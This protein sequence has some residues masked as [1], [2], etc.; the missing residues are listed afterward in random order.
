MIGHSTRTGPSPSG[1][2]VGQRDVWGW[3]VALVVCA[4]GSAGAGIPAQVEGTYRLR[5]VIHV[6]PTAQPSIRTPRLCSEVRSILADTFGPLCRLEVDPGDAH[7]SRIDWRALCAGHDH[8]C[9]VRVEHDRHVLRASGSGYSRLFDRALAPW[10]QAT[11]AP[12]MVGKL[13]ATSVVRSFVLH[14]RVGWVGFR[15]ARAILHGQS[16][17]G[18]C[19]QDLASGALLGI[20]RFAASGRPQRV[21]GAVAVLHRCDA[22]GI[23]LR[24]ISALL[25]PWGPSGPWIVAQLHP[26][27]G[28]TRLRLV[29]VDS[30]SGVGGADVYLHPER[31]SRSTQAL[32]GATDAQGWIE[33]RDLGA[34]LWHGQARLRGD[35]WWQFP[36]VPQGP[37]TEVLVPIQTRYPVVPLVTELEQMDRQVHQHAGQQK[38]LLEEARA[39]LGRDRLDEARTRLDLLQTAH[40]RMASLREQAQRLSADH[41][42]AAADLRR[43]TQRIFSQWNEQGMGTA[44]ARLDAELRAAGDLTDIDAAEMLRRAGQAEKEYDFDR[45][46]VWYKRASE[47]APK[48]EDIAKALDDLQKD[49]ETRDD[50]HRHA[51]TLAYEVTPQWSMTRLHEKSDA[52]EQAIKALVTYYDHRTLRRLRAMLVALDARLAR[53]VRDQR[54]PKDSPRARQIDQARQTVKKLAQPV[55]AFLKTIDKG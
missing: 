55:E 41:P 18:R 39:A 14:G 29:D 4:R 6:A 23:D 12:A 53:T 22:Q 2:P 11:V 26:R 40:K 9:V 3:V 42:L 51:R 1:A 24:V 8:V 35:T 16:L 46:L 36:L 34:R 33:L 15:R 20:Y 49:W 13:V 48:R 45:A 25:D 17:L 10:T 43:A 5:V 19:R 21:P 27:A 44:V 31:Y 7:T 47:K 50:A 54:I 30:G 52:L 37:N 32:R 38:R 28:T